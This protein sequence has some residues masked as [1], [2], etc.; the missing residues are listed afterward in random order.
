METRRSTDAYD[1]PHCNSLQ[2]TGGTIVHNYA[3]GDVLLHKIS[4]SLVGQRKMHEAFINAFIS[5][6]AGDVFVVNPLEVE[7]LGL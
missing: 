1:R 5:D 2:V 7:C 3:L 6:L 4:R